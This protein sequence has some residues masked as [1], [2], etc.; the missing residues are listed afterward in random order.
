MLKSCGLDEFG[1]IAQW[2][3]N[4]RRSR[5]LILQYHRVADDIRDPHALCVSRQHFSEHLEVLR[6]RCHPIS[7]Q[8]L[9]KAIQDRNLPKRAVVITFDDGYADNFYN[10]KPILERYDI[11]ATIFVVTGHIGTRQEF[12]WDELEVLLES[13]ARLG[14]LC[15][16]IAGKVYKWRLGGLCQARSILNAR[17]QQNLYRSLYRLLRP[18][19][20]DERQR[21]L[22]QLR[23]SSNKQLLEYSVRRVVSKDELFNLANGNLVEIGAHTVT[24]PVLSMLPLTDQRR[25]IQE[26]K[27][28]LE[29]VLGR[30]VTSFAYP[31]GLPSDYTAETVAVV[32]EAKF[33]CA[34]SSSVGPVWQDSNLFEL[35]RVPILDWNGDI[36]TW[37]LKW[38]SC[39]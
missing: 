39:A 21:V 12:W 28:Y 36:F 29:N 23:Q 16:E 18:L 5:V 4:K 37:I 15:L 6:Q 30:P 7:L 32:Q 19:S 26:S 14:L 11:P 20:E 2:L 3:K 25:E 33:D 9:V 31:F 38:W 35:P 24:H 27:I 34:C 1:R 10:A 13:K 17:M 8:K 22:R